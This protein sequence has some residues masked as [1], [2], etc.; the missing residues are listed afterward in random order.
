MHIIIIHIYDNTSVYTLYNIH[1]Y[2]LIK[3]SVNRSQFFILNYG[4]FIAQDFETYRTQRQVVVVCG[5]IDFK[6]AS[7]RHLRKKF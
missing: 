4:D 2:I 6:H 5:N 3:K 7:R 1:I